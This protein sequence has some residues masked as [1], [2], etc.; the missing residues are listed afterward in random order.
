[1]KVLVVDDSTV[2]RLVLREVLE[3]AGFVVDEASSGAEAIRILETN[4]YDLITMDIH[5]PDMSGYETTERILERWSVPIIIVTASANAKVA[6]TAIRALEVGALAVVE[7]P[8]SPLAA[9][10]ELTCKDLLRAVRLMKDV[11][12]VRRPRKATVPAPLIELRPEQRPLDKKIKVVAFSASAGGP[13]ALKLI[14][15]AIKKPLPWPVIINQH[16]A[17]GFLHGFADWLH[18]CSGFKVI[19]SSADQP[20][21]AGNLY[22][23][24]EGFH[25]IV[26][27]HGHIQL[28]PRADTDLICPSADIL[29]HSIADYA[30]SQA[31]GVQL[32]GMGRDGADGLAHM[33]KLGA[34][35]LVQQPES[36]MIASMPSTALAQCPKAIVLKPLEIAQYLVTLADT[37]RHSARDFVLSENNKNEL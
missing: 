18:A 2:V 7:K 33:Q 15:G 16:I 8:A 30:G 21:Y 13:A 22:L 17:V 12:I 4:T 1:M 29:L 28:R 11:K 14:L 10:F 20:L 32:S 31:I 5:M 19:I 35:I 37:C 27:Q 23:A 24:P 34:S 25:Q 9:N 6:S 3:E 36:T 26:D